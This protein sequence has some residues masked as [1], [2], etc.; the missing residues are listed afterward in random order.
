MALT[1]QDFPT[2]VRNS[3]AAIQARTTA[4]LDLTIGSVLRAILEANATVVLWLQGLI[5]QLLS[6][7]RAATSAGAALDSFFADFGFLRLA[8]VSASGVVTFA[9]FTNTYQA[10]IPVGTLI[11]TGD[12]TQQFIINADTTNGA[13]N[14]GLNGFVIAPGVSSVN[15]TATAVTV[16]TGANAL[17]GLISLITQPIP[18]V[19]TVTNGAA[20]TNGVNAESDAA[21]RTR[22]IAYI[23][24]LNLATKAAVGYAVTSL[25]SNMSYV[26]VENFTY[27]GVSQ[28]GYFYVVVN[29]G[30][31]AP[32][33]TILNSVSNAINLVRPF[34]S[35]FGVYA[36]VTTAANVAMT[37]VTASGY[38]HATVAAQVQSAISAYLGSMAIGQSL[39]F[40]RLAQIA[41]DTSPGITN[42]TGVTLNALTA[43]INPTNQQLV[44]AGTV[45][46]A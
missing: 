7:T 46:V 5:L 25:Q 37:I 40:S 30:T 23:Q 9:R 28:P 42:V 29:D 11:S 18:Y 27:G 22:F 13:Y 8:A 20:F 4:L 21:F 10:V 44:I 26:L 6:N 41:Y 16:G 34:T 2:I 15:V 38:I 35:T 36:P 12:G 3:V 19:D 14:A 24:S 39:S 45:T 32:G 43:D 33:S 1:S 31:G 17:V